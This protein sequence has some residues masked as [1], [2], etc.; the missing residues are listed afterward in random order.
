[1][2]I[3]VLWVCP[4]CGWSKTVTYDEPVPSKERIRC[5][6]RK[7]VEGVIKTCGSKMDIESATADEDYYRTCTDPD[8]FDPED[9]HYD[10]GD[11]PPE[12]RMEDE[13]DDDCPDDY[14]E[15]EWMDWERMDEWDDYDDQD[16]YDDLEYDDEYED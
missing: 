3:Y 6:R 12:R 15:N 2:A 7:K 14:D 10:I 4:S 13:W 9:R 8:P 5:Q 16:D 1:M 11:G